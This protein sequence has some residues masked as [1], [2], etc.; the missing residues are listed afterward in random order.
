MASAKSPVFSR[1]SLASSSDFPVFSITVFSLTLIGSGIHWYFSMK[2]GIKKIMNLLECIQTD[3]EDRYHQ[4]YKN[5][6]EEISIA[7]GQTKLKAMI[8]PTSSINSLSMASMNGEGVIALTE[9]AVSRLTRNELQALVAQSVARCATGEALM[10]TAACALGGVYKAMIEKLSESETSMWASPTFATSSS[11]MA[12]Q[13]GQNMFAYIF[14]YF[15]IRPDSFLKSTSSH[16]SF[17]F[18]SLSFF[19]SFFSFLSLPF[20]L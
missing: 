9:G 5:T 6:V 1:A 18:S 8:I 14:L 13:Q 16:I 12:Q 10:T 20:S 3:P 7:M 19:L 17:F 15:A 4:I 2:N 11:S